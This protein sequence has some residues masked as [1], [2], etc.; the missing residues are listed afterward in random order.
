MSLFHYAGE[1]K[2]TS[3]YDN[4]MCSLRLRSKNILIHVG[5]DSGVGPK[6]LDR[7]A[8]TYLIIR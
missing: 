4:F 8:L 1:S 5:V 2:N 6:S 7:G 3:E